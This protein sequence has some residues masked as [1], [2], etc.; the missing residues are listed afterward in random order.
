MLQMIVFDI[1]TGFIQHLI[2]SY[3]FVIK[4]RLP[5]LVFFTFGNNFVVFSGRNRLKTTHYVL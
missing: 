4:R 3:Y 1:F 5:K 2:V